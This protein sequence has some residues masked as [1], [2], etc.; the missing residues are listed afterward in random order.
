M[1]VSLGVRDDGAFPLE[2]VRD[3]AFD[4]L[5]LRRNSWDVPELLNLG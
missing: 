5:A 1:V 2:S 4:I 3:G